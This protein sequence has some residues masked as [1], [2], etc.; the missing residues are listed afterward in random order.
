MDGKTAVAKVLKAEGV[1]FVT[2]FPY[3]PI[4]DPIAAEGI[5]PVKAR[6]ERVAIGIADGF[7]RSSF[8]RRNGVCFVQNGPGSENSFAGIAQAFAD[9]VPVLFMPGGYARRDLKRPQF[10]AVNNYRE[11][12]KWAD[13]VHFADQIPT[14]MRRAFTYLRTGRPGPVLLEVP[15]DVTAEQF[16]DKFF[17]YSP[18]KGWKA[19]GD[20]VDV[21]RVVKALLATRNPVVRAGNGVLYAGAWD[22]L[23]EFAELLQ[24]PVFTTMQGK[25]AFPENHPLSLGTGGRTRPKMVMHFLKKADLVFAI[26]SSC[27]RET[28]TTNIPEGKTVIQSTIDEVDIGKDYPVAEAIIGDAKLVLAQLIAEIKKELGPN[29]RKGDGTVAGEIK[30]VKEEWVKEWLPKLTSDEVPISPY[31][32]VWDL[33]RT[34]DKNQSIVTPEAGGPRDQSIPFYE[35]T[36]PGGFIGWGKT[37]TLGGSLGFAMGAKLANPGKM[38]VNILGDAAMGMAGIDFET[39]VREKIP[40]LSILLNNSR[41]GGYD[42]ML[43]TATQRYSIDRVGGDYSKVVAAL[44]C[45]AER[46]EQ[47]GEIVPAIQRAK[48]ILA[49]GQPVFLEMITRVDTEFS[50]Y[51]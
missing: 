19:A 1:E 15:A 10:V 40:I 11:V 9:S 26:G 2:C 48:K 12:T 24:I 22:E 31:R 42:K 3:N 25:S 29:G 39:A 5:R 45:H 23:R 47:P 38:V 41:F 20:P 37:T 35:A 44:G 34:L 18:V 8:G 27:T 46:I 16:D 30:A 4:L 51:E 36:V 33:N 21:R 43:P 32:V 14:L 13:L 6:T 7:T 50:V 49:G 17:R 28:F